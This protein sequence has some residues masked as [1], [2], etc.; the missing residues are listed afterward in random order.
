MSTGDRQRTSRKKGPDLVD[1]QRRL[2]ER[3]EVMK[4]PT[5][6]PP[7]DSRLSCHLEGLASTYYRRRRDRHESTRHD[8]TQSAIHDFR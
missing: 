1:E 2:L 7:N 8:P 6:P 5:K 3:R 4:V